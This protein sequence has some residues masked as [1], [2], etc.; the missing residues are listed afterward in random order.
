[1]A[2]DLDYHILIR[3][4]FDS[5]TVGHYILTYTSKE[6]KT[7]ALEIDDYIT[8]YTPRLSATES[9]LENGES[10]DN[11]PEL[12]LSRKDGIMFGNRGL[13]YTDEMLKHA[14]HVSQKASEEGH[15]V[16][17]PIMSFTHEYLVEKGIVDPEM[18]KP[19]KSSDKDLGVYK[20]KVDQLKL[21]M[22]ITDMMDRYHRESGFEKPEWTATIQF[23]TTSVHAHITT[24]ET[25]TP[26]R[27]RMKQIYCDK[28]EYVPNMRWHIEK[29]DAY[30]IPR[31]NKDGRIE[32]LRNGEVIAK[33]NLTKNGEPKWRKVKSSYTEK[34]W[35]ERGKI[36]KKQQGRMREA[37][38]R[39]ISQTKDIKPFVKEV[40][41][42]KRLTKT[43]T[44][45][46]LTYNEQLIKK[47]QALYA[48]MPENKKMWRAG[49]NAKDMQRPHELANEILDDVWSRYSKGVGLNDFEKSVTEYQ[50]IRKKDENLDAKEVDQLKVNAYQELRKES[51]NAIYKNLKTF[52]EKDLGDNSV[53]LIDASPSVNYESQPTQQLQ[54]TIAESYHNPSYT[55]VDPLLMSAYRQREYRK[56]Y[57]DAYY[58]KEQYKSYMDHYDDLSQQNKTSDSSRVVRAYYQQEY[59]YHKK[60]F[61]KYSYL[62]STPK[63][64]KNNK[65][66]FDEV[67]GVDLVNMLYDYQKGDDRSVPKDVAEQYKIETNARSS[68]LNQTLNYLVDTEQYEQY[69]ILRDKREAI[70]KEADIAEQIYDELIIPIPSNQK[71]AYLIDQR[72]TIDTIQGRRLLKEE[73]K[74]LNTVTKE[75]KT[76]Y[77]DKGS[78]DID[79]TSLREKEDSTIKKDYKDDTIEFFRARR[80]EQQRQ[81]LHYYQI[82]KTIEDIDNAEAFI[83]RD[84]DSKDSMNHENDGQNKDVSVENKVEKAKD[85]ELDI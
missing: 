10:L 46:S 6:E 79:Y 60:K 19:D 35:V 37:F 64:R 31:K 51:I 58:E 25:A 11:E 39:S 23:D 75:L 59:E 67:K 30:Y 84:T 69:E 8:R 5:N 85:I 43:L 62:T 81:Q 40:K 16:V 18:P 4:Q 66:S 45:Q 73:I 55:K 49:S 48:A 24:I 47:M 78:K 2:M 74:S 52:T 32:Y 80:L 38:N 82:H 83:N 3:N 34:K 33:Q 27:K 41:D 9:L 68:A 71:D 50:H 72:K 57:K 56:R 17:L 63:E 15:V 36:E 21:R 77:R 22:A 65:A 44:I 53:N 14:A 61:D 26:N 54:N 76:N 70:R 28:N 20:G 7:E 42:Q 12:E 13:S 1:M 29:D